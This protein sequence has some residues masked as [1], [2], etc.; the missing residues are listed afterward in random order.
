MKFIISSKLPDTKKSE[1]QRNLTYCS[2][3]RDSSSN[4][5]FLNFNFYFPSHEVTYLVLSG[6][7]L[8]A[9]ISEAFSLVSDIF[10]TAYSAADQ[11]LQPLVQP[12]LLGLTTSFLT[13]GICYILPT[14]VSGP[15]E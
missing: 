9:V 2:L 4:F 5:D 12:V 14:L 10:P 1:V 13:A 6:P 11:R 8:L 3:L 15:D 7:V